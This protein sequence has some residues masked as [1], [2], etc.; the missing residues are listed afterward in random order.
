MRFDI[1][2]CSKLLCFDFVVVRIFLGQGLIWLT[3]IKAFGGAD[4]ADTK[5]R[6]LI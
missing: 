6:R 2:Q 5:K 1:F 4:A 3:D